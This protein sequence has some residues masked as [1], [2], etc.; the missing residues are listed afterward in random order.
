MSLLGCRLQ[1]M[2]Y[3]NGLLT[4]KYE[5]TLIQELKNFLP[6]RISNRLFKPA[7]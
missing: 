1:H 2:S 4:E 5:K 6:G 3:A 7:M